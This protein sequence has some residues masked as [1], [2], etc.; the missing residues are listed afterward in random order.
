MGDDI[1]VYEFRCGRIDAIVLIDVHSTNSWQDSTRSVKA[2]Q[3]SND[4]K[5]AGCQRKRVIV[6]EEQAITIKEFS[7]VQHN[8]TQNTCCN[9]LLSNAL[10]IQ[11]T[12][13]VLKLNQYKCFSLS[14]QLPQM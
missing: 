13:A 10:S 6:L 14:N 4:L 11:N 3:G 5:T 2:S 1:Q 12:A 9:V 8:C 7:K